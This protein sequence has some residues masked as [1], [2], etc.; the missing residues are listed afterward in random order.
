MPT[1]SPVKTAFLAVGSAVILSLTACGSTTDTP[2]AQQAAAATYPPDIA[3]A[4]DGAVIAD[5]TY[6]IPER[7][8]DEGTVII[9]WYGGGFGSGNSAAVVYRKNDGRLIPL[10]ACPLP[11]TDIY[12]SR[13]NADHHR[14]TNAIDDR[15][16]SVRCETKEAATHRGRPNPMLIIRGTSSGFLGIGEGD[17]TYREF[18]IL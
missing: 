14:I 18:G 8:Q 17:E 16:V 15:T 12:D 6:D 1:R 10:R 9:L 13:K 7:V 4:I 11:A 2:L 3:A 5:E